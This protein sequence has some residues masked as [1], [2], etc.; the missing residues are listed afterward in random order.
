MAAV[1]ERDAQQRTAADKVARFYD[2]CV[3][4]ANL[5][6][7]VYTGLAAEAQSAELAKPVSGA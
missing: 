7:T 6:E 5:L 1:E 3:N 2:G 4:L